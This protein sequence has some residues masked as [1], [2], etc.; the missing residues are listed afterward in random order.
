MKSQM[1][2]VIKIFILIIF[3]IPLLDGCSDTP[4]NTDDSGRLNSNKEWITLPENSGL[5][6]EEEYTASKFI[7]GGTG[8]ILSLTREYKTSGGKNFFLIASVEVPVGAYSGDKNIIMIVNSADGTTTFYPSPETFSKPLIFNLEIKGINL[9]GVDLK[10]L[11]FMYIASDGRFSPLEYKKIIVKS[12]SLE[13]K[14]ALIPHFSRYG[15][16]R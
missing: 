10:R 8:G 5:S 6:T 3:L 9:T 2:F 11:D 7:N 14:D 15:W 13:V 1:A 16:C 12:S 4:L